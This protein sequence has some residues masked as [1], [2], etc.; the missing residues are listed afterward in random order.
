MSKQLES[1][2]QFDSN[3]NISFEVRKIEMTSFS[4]YRIASTFFIE[5][6]FFSPDTQHEHDDTYI[7]L[8]NIF[9]QFCFSFFCFTSFLISSSQ[10]IPL[11]WTKEKWSF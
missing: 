11:K 3:N 10:L 2:I 1:R 4:F 7:S 5:F 6:Y 8:N 9:K